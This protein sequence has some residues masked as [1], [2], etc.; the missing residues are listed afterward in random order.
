MEMKNIRSRIFRTRVSTLYIIIFGALLYLGWNVFKN[1]GSLVLLVIF[2]GAIVFAGF[3]FRS[4]YYVLTDKEIQVYYLWSIVGRIFISAISSV[5]RSYNP[6]NAPAASLKRLCFHFKK[7]YK[8][9]HFFSD[10]IFLLIMYPSISPTREQEFLEI[11]KIIN[12]NIQINVNDKKGW[13][14]F[15]NW[16]F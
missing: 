7:G 12:P 5:E 11:L 9:H 2:I 13:W 6:L 16:D 4:M 8:W 14:R 3:A 10:S 1:S 15:W